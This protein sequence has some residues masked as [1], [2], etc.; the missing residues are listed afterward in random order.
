MNEGFA[1]ARGVYKT[2][3][4]ELGLGYQ[5]PEAYVRSGDY[6]SLGYMRPLA[7]WAIYLAWKQFRASGEKVSQEGEVGYGGEKDE[8]GK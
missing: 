3:Y 5:T 1:T 8:S 7:V 2:C 6:R 4:E